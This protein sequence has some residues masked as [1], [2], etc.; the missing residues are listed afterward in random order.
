MHNFSC[1]NGSR[2]QDY[3]NI[4]QLCTFEKFI[5]RLFIVTQPSVDLIP[6]TLTTTTTRKP[7][8]ATSVSVFDIAWGR[9]TSTTEKTIKTKTKGT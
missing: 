9:S 8:T 7:I 6:K 5:L 2:Y 1:N 4:L 3:L